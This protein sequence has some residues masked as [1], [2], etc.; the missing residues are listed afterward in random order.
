MHTRE[1][2]TREKPFKCPSCPYSTSYKGHLASH[3]RRRHTKEKSFKCLF[4][5]YSASDKIYLTRH[6]ILRHSEKKIKFT[7][8]VNSNAEIAAHTDADASADDSKH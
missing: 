4:C 5:T 3:I 2:Q 7:A 6:F 1:K 8:T